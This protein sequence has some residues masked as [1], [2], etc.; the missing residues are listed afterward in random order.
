MFVT[1]FAQYRNTGEDSNII[2]SN[3]SLGI[4]NINSHGFGAAYRQTK[5]K[6]AFTSN[7]FEIGFTTY[8][9]DKEQMMSSYYS[10]YKSYKYGKLNDILILRAGFGSQYLVS[11]KPY[12][13]GVEIQL[14]YSCGLSLCFAKPIYVYILVPDSLHTNSYVEALERY[15]PDEHTYVNI[16][17]KGKIWSGLLETKVYPGVYGK[18]GVVF[19]YGE[20]NNLAKAIELGVNLDIFPLAVPIMAYNDPKN[21]FFSFYLNVIF[22]NRY[23]K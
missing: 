1:S 11:R 7:F 8:R 19:E 15:D 5:I 2:Y 23:N 17:G 4:L 18:V 14:N 22:G 12:W 16:L 21:L 13:G 10:G 6:N 20:Y 9:D 3:E